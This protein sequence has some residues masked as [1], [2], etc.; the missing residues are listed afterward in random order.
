M[1]HIPD[2][3]ADAAYIAREPLRVVTVEQAG[4]RSFVGVPML[5]EGKLVGAIVI[6]RQGRCGPWTTDRAAQEFRRPGRA[7]PSRIRGCSTSCRQR[8]D[9]L[10]KSLEQQSATWEVLEC[11]FQLGDGC[12]ACVRHDC[13][14]APR[15]CARP[16]S[17]LCTG[18]MASFCTSWRTAALLLRC[19]SSTAAISGAANPEQ[20]GVAR[21][22]RATNCASPRCSADPE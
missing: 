13:R 18:L 20:R 19:W 7:S 5:K 9:D 2:L 4:A 3:K 16:N 1:F 8:T 14:T 15:N 17:A 22:P 6:Y 21:N 11:H 10:S 12:P